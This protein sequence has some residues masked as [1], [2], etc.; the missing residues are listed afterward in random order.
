VVTKHPGGEEL[1][2][3]FSGRDCTESFRTYHAFT[4]KPYPI[5][6]K[7]KIRTLK[8]PSELVRWK[9]DGGFYKAVRERCAEYFKQEKLDP[10]RQ[11]I[12]YEI[13]RFSTSLGAK[14]V[15]MYFLTHPSFPLWVRMLAAIPNGF[16]GVTIVVNVM[17]MASHV[18]TFHNPKFN[19]LLGWFSMDVL[20]GQSFDVWLHEHVVGHHQYTNVI[21]IDPN[22]PEGYGDEALYRGTTKQTFY[23]RFAYQFIWLPLVSFLLVWENRLAFIRY[24]TKGMRKEIR[25]S[26]FFTGTSSFIYFI[27]GKLFWFYLSFYMPNV[28]WGCPVWEN[29]LGI[30]LM[31]M[32]AGYFV[33]ITFPANHITNKVAWPMAIKD[34]KTGDMHVDAEWAVAQV[35]TTKDYAYDSWVFTNVFGSLNNHSCHHLFPAMHHSHYQK[36]YPIVKQAAKEFNIKLPDVGGYADLV[37]DYIHHLWSMG[38]E[39]DHRD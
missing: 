16:A 29:V 32:V 4:D 14:L 15:G 36:I 3:L 33:G 38:Y 22:C 1:I 35:Q 20:C 6:E 30:F 34:P 12:L 17:H 5:L 2:L 19:Y 9:P 13:Y 37:F 28:W 26:S 25:A 23:K 10:V 8:G 11:S 21:T 27:L 18:P 31:E 39:S 7:F 24:W